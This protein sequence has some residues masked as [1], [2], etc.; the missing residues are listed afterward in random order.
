MSR[1]VVKKKIEINEDTYL[2]LRKGY[3]DDSLTW[4]VNKLLDSFKSLHTSSPADLIHEA[5]INVKEEVE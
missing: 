2:W 4:I 5:A 1:R 3:P